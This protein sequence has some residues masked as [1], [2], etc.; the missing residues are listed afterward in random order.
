MTKAILRVY[1]LG[2]VDKI[3]LCNTLAPVTFVLW[4]EYMFAILEESFQQ[5]IQVQQQKTCTTCIITVRHQIFTA[6]DH[7]GL[8]RFPLKIKKNIQLAY[9]SCD[10]LDGQLFIPFVSLLPL[11]TQAQGCFV[12]HT[13]V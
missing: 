3:R 4:D 5:R 9:T 6:P 8:V 12:I 10:T 2:Y 7:T 1:F 11:K 13:P